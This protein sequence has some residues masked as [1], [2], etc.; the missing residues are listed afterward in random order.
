MTTAFYWLATKFVSFF[1]MPFYAHIDVRGI[2]NVPRKGAFVLVSN[3]LN[4]A[5]PGILSTRLPRRLVFMTKVELFKVPLLAQ[6]LRAYGAFPV[7]RGEADLSAL[8]R[9]NETLRAGMPLVLFPEGTR[10]GKRASLG[11]AWPGAGLIALRNNVPIVPCAITGSQDMAMPFMFL[12]VLRRRQ[13]TLT[14]GKPFSLP[15]PARINAESSAA[16][17][18]EVMR[19]IAELLP[20][21]YRGYYGEAGSA[22]TTAVAGPDDRTEGQA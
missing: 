16:G 15:Q 4:D 12:R 22:P 5:D 18:A 11:Q 2:E 7:R 10:A 14:I 21:S 17:A 6:F 13:V 19:R 3:H 1:M 9:S 8:R 20:E